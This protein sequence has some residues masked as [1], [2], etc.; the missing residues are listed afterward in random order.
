MSSKL[1]AVTAHLL[2]GTP[3]I[4]QGEELGMTNAG[5]TD[6][7]QYRDVESLNYFKIL[8]E[9]GCSPQATSTSTSIALIGETPSESRRSPCWTWV[10]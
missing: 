1:L 4:Y 3:Y 5:F 2:R 10:T 6:I 8:Q 7:T 9:R